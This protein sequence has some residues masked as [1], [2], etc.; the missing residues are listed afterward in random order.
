MTVNIQEEATRV[1]AT[2]EGRLDTVAASEQA[3]AFKQISEMAGK[4]IVLD[5]ARLSY[6]SSSG[7]RLFLSIRKEAE[8]KGGNVVV[9]DINSEIRNVFDITGFSNLFTIE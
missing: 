3:S 7:L 9:K 2:L 1:T 8:A 4:T 6:I 5:C